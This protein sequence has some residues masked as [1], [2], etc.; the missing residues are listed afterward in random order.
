MIYTKANKL[1]QKGG[2]GL[3]TCFQGRRQSF[4]RPVQNEEVN[5]AVFNIADDKSPRPDG[6][7]AGFFK[8]AWSVIGKEVI[9]AILEF[10][11]K[12]RL[13]N[14]VNA[15]L[16]TLIPKVQMPKVVANYRPIACCNVLYKIITKIMVQRLKEVL[17][18]VVYPNQNAFI[19]KLQSSIT[20]S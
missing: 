5:E 14:Q 17:V 12:G 2:S 9:I 8:V 6:Y 4:I 18:K 15:T 7:S 3:G 10:F 16:L 13:L 19:P 20:S 11:S 1:E